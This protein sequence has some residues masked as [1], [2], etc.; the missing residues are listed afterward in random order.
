MPNNRPT[1]TREAQLESEIQ[2]ALASRNGTPEAREEPRPRIYCYACA[3]E[4]GGSPDD[5]LEGEIIEVACWRHE[6]PEVSSDEISPYED[7]DEDEDED[8]NEDEDVSHSAI[9]QGR[10]VPQGAFQGS[11]RAPRATRGTSRTP[12]GTSRTPQGSTRAPRGTSRGASTGN[13]HARKK[14]L[15]PHEAKQRLKNAG[16]D[17]SRDFH[18][19]S[20][21]QK[22]LL[23][24]SVRTTGYRKRKDAPGSTARMYFQYLARL[25]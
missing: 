9:R 10:S 24:A 15:D 18:Q 25:R 11:S 1:R 16:I 19:L 21:N 22:D 7:E 23:L 3:L 12:R 2:Q 6:D 5:E 17:F 4:T 20:S 8:E 14:K 13:L